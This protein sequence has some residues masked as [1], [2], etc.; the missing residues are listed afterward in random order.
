[1]N[2]SQPQKKDKA[3]SVGPSPGNTISSVYH[4]GEGP[5]SF[6]LEPTPD[7]K[8]NYPSRRATKRKQTLVALIDELTAL[9][10]D[11]QLEDGDEWSPASI[12]GQKLVKLDSGIRRLDAELSSLTNDVHPLGPTASLIRSLYDL[13]KSLH[14]VHSL[15]R[16]NAITISPS[17]VQKTEPLSL[18]AIVLRKGFSDPWNLVKVPVLMIEDD[19]SVPDLETFPEQMK[20]LAQC[21]ESFLEFLQDIPEFTDENLANCIQTA[22]ADLKYWASCLADHKEQAKLSAPAVQRYISYELSDGM[23]ELT[24][25]FV[26]ALR[27]FRQNGISYIKSAQ[28]QAQI[29]LQNL[30][31]IATFFSAMTAATLQFSWNQQGLLSEIVNGLWIG[32]LVLSL[33]SAVYFQLVYHWKAA[34]YQPPPNTLPWLVPAWMAT[35]PSLFLVLSVLLFL[36]GLVAW[37]FASQQQLAVSICT[38]FLAFVALLALPTM[39]LMWTAYEYWKFTNPKQIIKDRSRTRDQ[40][41]DRHK[42]NNWT[43]GHLDNVKHAIHRTSSEILTRCGRFLQRTFEQNRDIERNGGGGRD[44]PFDKQSPALPDGV[45]LT[46]EHSIVRPTRAGSFRSTRF[47]IIR[48]ESRDDHGPATIPR[49]RLSVADSN[50]DP[51][52]PPG[53]RSVQRSASV[54]PAASAIQSVVTGLTDR[55]SYFGRYNIPREEFLH[56]HHLD[57][58]ASVLEGLWPSQT[59]QDEHKGSI[60]HLQFSPD[61]S[62]LA[63]GSNDHTAII[64]KRDQSEQEE[65]YSIHFR[66]KHKPKGSDKGESV[67]QVAWSPT[68]DHL[69]TR[70]SNMIKIWTTQKREAPVKIRRDHEVQEIAW[71]LDGNSF[72][73]LESNHVHILVSY[74]RIHVGQNVIHFCRYLKSL[75]GEVMRTFEF[76]RRKMEIHNFILIDWQDE[77]YMLFIASVPKPEEFKSSK[78]KIG[79]RIIAY[80]L[81]S[82]E[83]ESQSPLLDKA[84][85]VAIGKNGKSVLVSYEDEYPPELWEIFGGEDGTTLN[86]SLHYS[87]EVDQHVEFAGEAYFGGAND[88]LIICATK[89][90]KIHIWDTQ[91]G[92]LLPPHQ[93]QHVRGDKGRVT[94]I[95]WSNVNRHRYMLASGHGDGTIRLWRAKVPKTQV[96]AAPEE[97]SD[98]VKGECGP[99]L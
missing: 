34:M 13:R 7:E 77:E 91:S 51:L 78:C 60:C 28:N 37:T 97:P 19:V 98:S 12:A 87:C 68:G 21:I 49:S 48:V 16:K 53:P 93:A 41:K 2:G 62:F 15:F 50:D 66:V 79:K 88:E 57:G 45:S 84:R 95:A 29:R 72:A 47:S 27:V 3:L 10:D 40:E 54:A 70:S 5:P 59:L 55:R 94:G 76:E 71:L 65:A 4:K 35:T 46:R 52:A 42:P 67:Q 90:G 74:L 69:L 18:E 25:G 86:I 75:T 96:D 38:T 11:E 30:S 83:V 89:N 64:W 99:S 43:S 31:A 61:G 80:N 92:Y 26:E 85:N 1:M 58:V 44:G 17:V 8:A 81:Q 56:G 33:A 20:H 32:S 82:R 36:T 73:A 6:F 24:R 22:Q 39:L 14:Q 23:E 63:S 9:R